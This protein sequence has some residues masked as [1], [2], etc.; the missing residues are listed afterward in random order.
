MV[1]L[2]DE[3]SLSSI[4]RYPIDEFEAGAE[5][6]DGGVKWSVHIG[7][8]EF[9]GDGFELSL[10]G[11]GNKAREALIRLCKYGSSHW[12]RD[13]IDVSGVLSAPLYAAPCTRNL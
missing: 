5:E 4:F 6:V 7:R 12:L 13:I 9:R 8:S 1:I 3:G 2:V 10:D 11:V